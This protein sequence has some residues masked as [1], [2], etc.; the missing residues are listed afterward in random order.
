MTEEEIEAAIGD[1]HYLLDEAM[2]D[3]RKIHEGHIEALNSYFEAGEGQVSE[4]LNGSRRAHDDL[5]ELAERM[6]SDGR[7]L[8]LWLQKYVVFA[9]AK[10]RQPAKRGRKVEN[11]NTCRG[12]AITWATYVVVLRHDLQPTRNPATSVESGCSIIAKAFGTARHR[13]V[14]SKRQ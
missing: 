10:G 12:A 8:P 13:H 3:S 14:R 2:P 4:A 11:Y 5:C 6:T 9:A 1:A 7:P